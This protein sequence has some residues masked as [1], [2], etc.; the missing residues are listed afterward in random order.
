MPYMKW[1]ANTGV[2]CKHIKAPYGAFF[3]LFFYQCLIV[4]DLLNSPYYYFI[5]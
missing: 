5:V 2:T 3:I 1:E 4:D